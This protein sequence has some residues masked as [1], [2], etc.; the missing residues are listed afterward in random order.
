MTTTP[1]SLNDPTETEAELA[2]KLEHN[3]E[4]AK[5]V[6]QASEKRAALFDGSDP[7][8]ATKRNSD[9]QELAPGNPRSLEQMEKVNPRGED[10][11][12]VAYLDRIFG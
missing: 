4:I 6:K 12:P 7:D 11:D 5:L 10:E 3:P 2:A 1:R 9:E 8:A